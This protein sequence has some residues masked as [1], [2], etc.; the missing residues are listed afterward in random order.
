MKLDNVRLL[1]TKFEECY[2]FYKDILGLTCTW[3]EP[4]SAYASFTV[5][6]YDTIALFK[7]EYMAVSLGKSHLPSQSVSQDTFALIIRV[8]NLE[9]VAADL[10]AKGADITPVTEQTEWGIATAHVR[11]PEGNLIELMTSLPREKW[12]D[13]LAE[14]D[15]KYTAGPVTI[16]QA[17]PA[18][19]PFMWDML[20]E[21][22][23]VHEGEEKP[24]RAILEIKEIA[25][26][27]SD[28]GRKGDRGWIAVSEEKPVGA[29]WMR[30]MTPDTKTYGWIDDHVPVVSGLAVLPEFRGNGIGRALVETLIDA[31]RA[32]GF[33]SLSLSVDPRNPARLL[34]EDYG[35]TKAGEEGTS[36]T[37]R[38]EL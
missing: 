19:I 29:I 24:V 23:Y 2:S 33:S 28:W 6:E 25:L 18:D 11:D 27:L 4:D 13:S 5:S 9:R 12:H 37:M 22:V 14:E 17:E 16:R 36:W 38:T 8:E 15:E 21:S 30:E 3:G 31:A 34:Y 35:F 26:F 7:R 20:Y 1:V 32:E 10:K